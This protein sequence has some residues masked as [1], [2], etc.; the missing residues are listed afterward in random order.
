[1]QQLFMEHLLCTRA[2]ARSWD[3]AMSKTDKVPTLG[4]SQ[5]V[6]THRS[7]LGI[8][9]RHLGVPVMRDSPSSDPGGFPKEAAAEMWGGGVQGS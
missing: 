8:T 9:E 3:T 5:A 6:G 1:M 2:N 7:G 4:G